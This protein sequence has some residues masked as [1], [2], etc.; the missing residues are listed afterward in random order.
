MEMDGLFSTAT[1]V[2]TNFNIFGL[3]GFTSAPQLGSLTLVVPHLRID[4][5]GSDSRPFELRPPLIEGSNLV[6]VLLNRLRFLLLL[7]C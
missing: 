2:H 4:A 7:A 3:V 5:A 6:A 1:H